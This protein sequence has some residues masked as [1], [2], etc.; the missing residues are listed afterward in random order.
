MTTRSKRAQSATD[1][2]GDV[3]DHAD[4]ESGG[5][6]SHSEKKLE[7]QTLIELTQRLALQ[8]PH[9]L[10]NLDLDSDLVRAV[11]ALRTLSGSAHGRQT[12]FVHGLLR[13]SDIEAVRRIL[14][15]GQ[16][17][18]YGPS[19]PAATGPVQAWLER[20]LAEGD[21][22]LNEIVERHPETDRQRCRQLMRTAAKTP[23]T[24]ASRRA[25]Q[26]LQETLAGL[27]DG[28]EASDPSNAS[29]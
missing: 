15:R 12:K 11:E 18:S 27:L 7:R 1:P 21:T 24:P 9:E 25:K 6:Q 10:E 16:G 13:R 17:S 4:A 20:L 26:S 29:K 28:E 14:D 5:R 19:R 2:Q 3:P 23:P 22:A 8:R